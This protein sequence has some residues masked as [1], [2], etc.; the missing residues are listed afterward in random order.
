[1][2]TDRWTD[3]EK[4]VVTFH[5]H[6]ENM[7]TNGGYTKSIQ[8]TAR[9]ADRQNDVPLRLFQQTENDHI[10]ILALR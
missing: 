1:M 2:Q 8:K 6:V 10:S 5:N 3:L 9:Q 7:P 4:P